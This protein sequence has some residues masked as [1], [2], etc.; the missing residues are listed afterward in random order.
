MRSPGAWQ[1]SLRTPADASIYFLIPP[2]TTQAILTLVHAFLAYGGCAALFW[3]PGAS[4]VAR[5]HVRAFAALQ[6]V[7]LAASAAQLR[8]G[9]PPL[10]SVGPGAGRQTPFFARHVGPTGFALAA[11]VSAVPFL[12]EARALID[13]AVTPTTLALGDWLKLD[14]IAFSLHHAACVRSMREQRRVGER[15][16][17]GAKAAQ[18][19]ALAAGLMLLIWVPLLAFSAGNPTY[20]VPGVAAFGVTADF[21]GGAGPLDGGVF[22]GGLQ[23][24]GRARHDAAHA[25]PALG[26]ARWSV[27]AVKQGLRVDPSPSPPPPPLP[28]ALT[29]VRLFTSGG[30]TAIGPWAPAPARLPPELADAG[31]GRDQLQLACAAPDS[32]GLWPA[33]PPAAAAVAR[34]LEGGGDAGVA[35]AW[36]LTRSAP[37][38]SAHGGP[39]CE[40]R[41]HVPL[42]ARGR[43]ELLG[44]LRGERAR[45]RLWAAAFPNGTAAPRGTRALYPLVWHMR[46]S[47]CAPTPG[48]GDDVAAGGGRVVAGGAQPHQVG[49]LGRGARS[50]AAPAGPPDPWA[51]TAVACDVELVRQASGGSDGAAEHNSCGTAWWRLACEP[52][53]ADGS[54]LPSNTTASTMAACAPDAGGPRLVAVLDR[55]QA[56]VVGAALSSFGVG[57]LYL[58][59]VLG[60]ARFVRFSTRNVSLGVGSE[61]GLNVRGGG[62]RLAVRVGWP[63]P[64]A[65]TNPPWRP[66]S[67]IPST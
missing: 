11:I 1:A 22:A 42:A 2:S 18:G 50:G 65:L 28:A 21:V 20:Q 49:W 19:A 5:A 46:G 40:A 63:A 44:V 47:A 38:P 36:S 17:R 43:D 23:R 56:G 29:R 6:T 34:A 30:R 25:R 48:L 60:A 15:Q 24:A 26:L 37:L 27:A 13:W 10:A 51:S 58:T 8:S 31:Y 12:F 39:G 9:Y 52:V 41:V 14:D 57:G 32:D 64:G 59:F 7:S 35:L 67:P 16:S 53:A 45:A 62:G 33:S 3:R 66:P 55:V 4:A 61:C 54:L